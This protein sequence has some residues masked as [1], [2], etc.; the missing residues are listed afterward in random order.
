MTEIELL[1]Q[2]IRLHSRLYDKGTPL[3]TDGEYD[4]L[5]RKRHRLLGSDAAQPVAPVVV[6]APVPTGSPKVAHPAV[7]LSL[8][9]ASDQLE[10]G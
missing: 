8:N 9:N 5:V 2:S 3:I 10:E 7:M 4:E 6:G 1:E